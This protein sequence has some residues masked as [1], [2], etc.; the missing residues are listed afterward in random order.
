MWTQNMSRIDGNGPRRTTIPP[1]IHIVSSSWKFAGLSLHRAFSEIWSINGRYAREQ[2]S[3]R[4][5]LPS[6]S[7]RFHV[8]HSL[9]SMRWEVSRQTHEEALTS[10]N[11]SCRSDLHQ[12]EFRMHSRKTGQSICSR[13]D[14]SFEYLPRADCQTVNIVLLHAAITS[15][16]SFSATV[17]SSMPAWVIKMRRFTTSISVLACWFTSSRMFTMFITII[18]RCEP[19][20]AVRTA[21]DKGPLLTVDSTGVGISVWENDGAVLKPERR[22]IKISC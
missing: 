17:L 20:L 21:M 3:V 1:T 4:I 14:L 15:H 11:S 19:C 9:N 16:C 22:N 7:S 5:K 18:N 13:S 8:I 12:Y 2:Y 6:I 10:V